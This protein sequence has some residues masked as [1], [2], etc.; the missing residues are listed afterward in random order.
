MKACAGAAFGDFSGRSAMKTA[1]GQA[2]ARSQRFAG[3]KL[4]LLNVAV[5]GVIG[6]SGSFHYFGLLLKILRAH[7]S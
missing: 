1:A 2:S 3:G 7:A 5:L 6:S 4:N